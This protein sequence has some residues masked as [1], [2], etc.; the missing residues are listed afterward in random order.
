MGLP[1][2]LKLFMRYQM[3]LRIDANGVTPIPAPTRSTVS[4]YKSNHLGNLNGH[5]IKGSLT[6]KKSS[7]ALPKG[8]STMTRGK[9]RLIRA[10]LALVFTTTSPSFLSPRFSS[11]ASKSQ[12]RAL[13]NAVVKSPTTR[14]WTEM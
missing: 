1:D 13:A 6:F 5:E 12:P 10:G 4:Y 2:L 8:P 7:L 9:T 3:V 14:M 11:L